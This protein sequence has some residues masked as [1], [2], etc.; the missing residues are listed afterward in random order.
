MTRLTIGDD[1]L[2]VGDRQSADESR[3]LIGLDADGVRGWYST[4]AIKTDAI[5]RVG[6]DG[7]W[8]RRQVNYSARVVSARFNMFGVDRAAHVAIWQ[9]IGRINRTPQVVHYEDHGEDTFVRAVIEFDLPG[10]RAIQVSQGSFVATA[11]DPVRYSW[12]LQTRILTSATVT[13]GLDYPVEYPIDYEQETT[14]GQTYGV[15]SNAG[16]V[17]GYP[18]IV[19]EGRLPS[20]F[21]LLDST[22]RSIRYTGPVYPGTPVVVD[23]Q[24]RAVLVQGKNMSWAL[25]RRE[26]FSV[27]PN[28]GSLGISFVPD[29]VDA[30]RNSQATVQF[31]STYI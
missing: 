18:T 20:G 10:G 15:I 29:T 2:M 7:D 3:P 27:P 25:T 1:L 8:A 11:D 6:A 16:N 31:R 14:E 4:P 23:C 9:R 26:W 17:E 22:G 19:V 12:A 24:N 5:S 13:G 30:A 21:T 28:G